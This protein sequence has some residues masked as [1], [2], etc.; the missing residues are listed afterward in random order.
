MKVIKLGGSL[1]EQTETL[2]ALF[3]SLQQND[4]D[5][6]LVHGGGALVH[7]WLATAGLQSEKVNGLRVSPEQHMLYI[8]GGLAG[9]ANKVLMK[10]A[11]ASGLKPIG[12]TLYEAGVNCVRQSESLGQVGLC[13]VSST[14]PV[15]ALLAD[16]LMHGYLPIISSIGFGEN[17]EWFNVNADDAAV[18]VAATYHA[19]LLLIT[20]VEAVLDDRGNPLSQLN[21]E[22]IEKLTQNGVI[23][24][25][26]E[27]K[28]RGALSAAKRL[29]RCVRIGSWNVM[30]NPFS[31]TQISE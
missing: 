6:V 20:D 3:Q 19:D 30:N 25:G 23:K 1:L 27:V 21:S 11:I 2:G 26:M 24:D 7:Q 8:V 9:T 14:E 5:I 31:G 22:S 15:P 12:M 17:G 29:R 16:L 28:V 10:Q 4:D 18:A 13:Q